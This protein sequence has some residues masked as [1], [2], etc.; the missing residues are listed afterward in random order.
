MGVVIQNTCLRKRYNLSQCQ[1]CIKICPRKS[2]SPEKNNVVVDHKKC[3]QCGACT[4]ACPASAITASPP[5]RNIEQKHLYYDSRTP[6]QVKELLL[7]FHAGIRHIHL[8][9]NNSDW[10][11]YID[12][13]NQQLKTMGYSG[14]D[15]IQEKKIR[16]DISPMRR[17][18]L[19]L[20]RKAP[21]SITNKPLNQIFKNYQFYTLTLDQERC[22]LCTACENLC[23]SKAIEIN[24]RAYTIH[25]QQCIGCHLCVDACPEK[26]LMLEEEIS[27]ETTISYALQKYTCTTCGTSF[28]SF[29]SKKHNLICSTCK[30]REKIGISASS[31]SKNSI[32]NLYKRDDQQ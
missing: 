24:D 15:I 3:D 30:I 28:S 19:G 25:T 13:A 7:Y 26:C 8:P 29:S 20:R 10:T 22:T 16:E 31:I 6:P 5:V 17:S 32:A 27:S 4:I 9:L 11:P 1:A 23:A 12:E 2:I 14:F 18:L 21:L